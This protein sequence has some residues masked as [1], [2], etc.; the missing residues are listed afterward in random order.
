V[1]SGNLRCGKRELEMWELEM[2]EVEMWEVRGGR[3]EMGLGKQG[4]RYR[5]GEALR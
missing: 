1:G 5:C 4:W 3:L 2:W